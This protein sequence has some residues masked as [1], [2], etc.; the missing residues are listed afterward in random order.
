MEKMTSH[1]FRA[2]WG[3]LFKQM[4]ANRP[5]MAD[6][7]FLIILNLKYQKILGLFY[8][9]ICYRPTLATL[10]SASQSTAISQKYL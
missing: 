10:I 4:P 2:L 7:F 1:V 9:K 5:N 6:Q 3:R 8:A